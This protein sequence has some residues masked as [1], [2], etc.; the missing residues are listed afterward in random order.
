MQFI[1][2][3]EGNKGEGMPYFILSIAI[4][5]EVIGTLAL[6]ASDGFSRPVPSL[7][8]VIG[9]GIAFY[10]LS[11]VLKSISVGVA[12]A[13]WSGCGIVLV[14]LLGWLWFRQSLDLPAML[15]MGM[16]IAGVAVMNLFSNTVGS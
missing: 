5:A 7:I 9:Y 2:I 13:I 10:G 6:K 4:I 15:G 11:L 3:A 14:A 8:T 16:I 1:L 12:Y